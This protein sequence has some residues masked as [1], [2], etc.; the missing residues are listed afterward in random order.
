M[1]ADMKLMIA[2][3]FA[4]MAQKRAI[5]KITVKDLVERCGISR[6]TFYYHFQDLLD[7]MEW[8]LRQVMEEALQKCLRAKTVEESIQAFIQVSMEYEGF[9][10]RL[11]SSDQ[12][13][14]RMEQ[15]FV[16]VMRSGIRKM[17][18]TRQPDLSI[19]HQ[20]LEVTLNFY[21]YGVA[22]V[23]LENCRGARLDAQQ[24]SQK[25]LLLLS[26]QMLTL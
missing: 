15:I 21:A 24:L 3:K 18:Y 16:D 5:D 10:I 11:L 20:D 7:V 6:Q 12:H 8:S 2:S 19:S 17:M 9:I 1:P 26:G 14:T 13:R 4:E 22:G 23:L 25:L